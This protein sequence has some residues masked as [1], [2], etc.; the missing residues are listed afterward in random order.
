[1]VGTKE[2]TIAAVCPTALL[3]T[4]VSPGDDFAGRG[5][6]NKKKARTDMQSAIDLLA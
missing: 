2:T 3:E 4:M 5:D 1:L 6:K